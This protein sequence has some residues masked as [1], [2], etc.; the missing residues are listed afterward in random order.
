MRKYKSKK[1][2]KI[3]HKNHFQ[4]TSTEVV[5]TSKNFSILKIGN[6]VTSKGRLILRIGGRGNLTVLI[7]NNLE[8]NEHNNYY[9]VTL[10]LHQ[11]SKSVAFLVDH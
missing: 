6:K 3:F 8:L 5:G 7:L 2:L 11:L 1:K 9:R 4:K 10:T